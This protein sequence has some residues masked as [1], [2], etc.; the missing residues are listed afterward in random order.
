MK[1]ISVSLAF[2]GAVTGLFAAWYW[3]RSSKVPIQPSWPIEPG[4]AQLSQT[5]WVAGTMNAFTKAAK[6][7][8]NA[9][10]LTAVSVVLFAASTLVGS[11]ADP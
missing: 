5:G 8:A 11:W 6:L 9:A 3:Y 10:C 7:N 1:W 2:A 4:D